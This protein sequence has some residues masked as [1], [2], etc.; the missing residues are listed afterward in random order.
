MSA[1]WIKEKGVKMRSDY[2]QLSQYDFREMESANKDL[3][4]ETVNCQGTF[5]LV[6]LF[7]VSYLR[8]IVEQKKS[9]ICKTF[10][11]QVEMEHKYYH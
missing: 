11:F 8:H 5:Q 4:L 3:N 7:K 6:S 9:Q 10:F 2:C 1:Q